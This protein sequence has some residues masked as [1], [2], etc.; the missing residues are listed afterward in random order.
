VSR[1]VRRI[2]LRYVLV[3]I[4]EKMG[5]LTSALA[6]SKASLLNKA[7]QTATLIVL[8]ITFQVSKM[9]VFIF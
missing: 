8:G 4:R 1:V 9:I 3:E 5:K 2:Y 7:L 6:L